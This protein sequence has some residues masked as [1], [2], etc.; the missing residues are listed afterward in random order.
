MGAD[1]DKTYTKGEARDGNQLWVWFSPPCPEGRGKPELGS[2]LRREERLLSRTREYVDRVGAY[3]DMGEGF[4]VLPFLP[5]SGTT[6]VAHDPRLCM[7]DS[8]NT[9]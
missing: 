8:T 3:D 9:C 1:R 7:L 5:R 2:E 6:G 4:F